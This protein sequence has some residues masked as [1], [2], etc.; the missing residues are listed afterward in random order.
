MHVCNVMLP[1]DGGA[2]GTRVTNDMSRAH[3][4]RLA[5]GAGFDVPDVSTERQTLERV[6]GAGSHESNVYTEA[7]GVGAKCN[8]C[9]Y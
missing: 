3:L 6:L 4:R 9:L 7:H 2:A 5:S 1:P 8:L